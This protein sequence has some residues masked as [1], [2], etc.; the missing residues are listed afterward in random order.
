MADFKL[1]IKPVLNWEGGY[2]NDPDDQGGETYRGITRKNWPYWEGWEYVDDADLRK[3]Q[4]SDVADAF[5]E[6][7]YREHYWAKIKGDLIEDQRTAGFLLDFFV[8]SGYHAIKAVQK[9]VGAKQDGIVGPQTLAAVN[10]TAGV[11]EALKLARIS[12]V[13]KAATLKN[14]KKFLA[15]WLRRINSFK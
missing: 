10:N 11:F 8:N 3:G 7:F 12:F 6:D 2:V 13:K 5:V 1:A 9:V 4:T 14:N 15:G